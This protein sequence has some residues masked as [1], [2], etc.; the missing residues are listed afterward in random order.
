MLNK[1]LLKFGYLITKAPRLLAEQSVD[2]ASML[3]E[4]LT[5]YVS[6]KDADHF[7]DTFKYHHW[8]TLYETMID[9]L[10]HECGPGGL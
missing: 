5:E 2:S 10:K 3:P 4:H 1:L 7:F 8:M 9:Y 6:L